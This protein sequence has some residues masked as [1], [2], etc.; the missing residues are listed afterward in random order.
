MTVP[1]WRSTGRTPDFPAKVRVVEVGAR[2]G[3]Q[4]VRQWVGTADKIALVNGLIATGI[5]ELEVSSF[6]PPRVV[7]QLRDAAAVFAGADRR[8]GAVLAALVPNVRGVEAAIA[9]GADRLVLV[10]S[11]SESHNRK[12]MNA[13]R[14]ERLAALA[15]MA[16]IA[17]AAGVGLR[18]G[19]AT[20]FGCPFEG[21]VP[22]AD[23][24]AVA[25][26]YRGAGITGIMLGDTTGMATPPLVFERCAALRAAI[27]DIEIAL[28]FHNTRGLGLANVLAGLQA[29]VAHFESSVGGIGGCPFVPRATGNICTEDLVHLLHECGIETGIDLDALCDVALRLQS[30][31]GAEL[32]GQVMK[33][34][35]RLRISPLDAAP[36]AAG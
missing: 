35:P 14:A 36:T 17:Q 8:S 2:D 19:I 26:A 23:V 13:S 20:A 11:A 3:L 34:G 10:V 32:P 6:V 9:A 16:G 21:D 28:H 29:G 30:L 31:L 15:E 7:P 12:N 5:P 24:V 25:R 18:G 33:A 4:S 27:P 22:V 1:E